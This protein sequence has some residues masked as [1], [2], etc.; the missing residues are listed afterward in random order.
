MSANEM[1]IGKFIN[2]NENDSISTKK[3]HYYLITQ[4]FIIDIP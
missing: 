1:E 2:W 3:N 4:D